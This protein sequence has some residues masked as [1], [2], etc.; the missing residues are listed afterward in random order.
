M[1][2]LKTKLRCK[3]YSC[4]YLF[5]VLLDLKGTILVMILWEIYTL[6]VEYKETK[7]WT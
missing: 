1:F 7:F 3:D 2:G 5:L 4:E 6:N